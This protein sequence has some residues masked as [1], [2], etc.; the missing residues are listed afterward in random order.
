MLGLARSAHSSAIPLLEYEA[1][2]YGRSRGTHWPT[3]SCSPADESWE[4]KVVP[5]KCRGV[6][7]RAL[8]SLGSSLGAYYGPEKDYEHHLER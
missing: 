8:F 5:C 1:R 2:L 7:M 4:K 6:A 3:S